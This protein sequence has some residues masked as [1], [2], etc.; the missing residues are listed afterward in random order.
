[1][2]K[3]ENKKE[4]EYRSRAERLAIKILLI[5]SAVAAVKLI[6][7]DYTMDEEYQIVMGYRLLQGDTLFGSMWEPHQTS[8]FL[9]AWLMGLYHL[10]TGSYTGVLV[11][12]RVVTT[13][14]QVFLAWQLYRVF[15]WQ[16][17][18]K[19]ALLAALFYFNTV[20]KLIQIPEFSNLQVWFFT[21]IYLALCYWRHELRTHNRRM[22]CRIWMVAAGV[23]MAAEVLAYPSCI[24]LFPFCLVAI[25]W[26]GNR[27]SRYAVADCLIFAGTCVLCGGLY[28]LY[29]LKNVPFS[30][31]LRNLHYIVSFDL[32]HELSGAA[33]GKGARIV[34]NIKDLLLYLGVSGIGCAA[35]SMV[36]E[37]CGRRV[38]AFESDRW[39]RAF[40]RDRRSRG[41]LW[42][43][44]M[45]I[46]ASFSQVF[47]WTIGGGSYEYYQLHLTVSY[48][49]GIAGMVFLLKRRA[50]DGRAPGTEEMVPESVAESAVW[51]TVPDVSLEVAGIIGS[52]V[53]LAAVVYIS[54]L[55]LIC[56]LP[57]ALLGAVL[58][59]VVL[60]RVLE[61]Q[62]REL[63]SAS[64]E[65]AAVPA[66]EALAMGEA[67]ATD[68]APAMDVRPLHLAFW[69]MAALVLC[70]CVGKGYTMR[71]GR[72]YVNVLQ[73]RNV[74]KSGPAVG[75]LAD[76]M[77]AY[78][79]NDNYAVWRENIEDGD[80]VLIVTN[81]VHAQ[82]TTPYLF[83]DVE[84]CHFSTVDPTSY[85]E[86][87]LTYWECY[88]EKAPNVIVVDCWYGN[89]MES[90]DSWIMK[91]IEE[92]FGYT[93]VVDGNYVRIYRK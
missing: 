24:I 51:G 71:A 52:L 81:M 68:E 30:E 70:S 67:Y 39:S 56:S 59:A 63:S 12:L 27:Y 10:V 58:G 8:A 64:G 11:F 50:V 92:D 62:E 74:M 43:A 73:T 83:R 84:V 47:V 87:L 49:M 40:G 86:K 3:R 89:L 91:Y 22:V 69:V 1:M 13:G 26:L 60:V 90:A 6:L 54:D 66:G 9:C 61:A 72:N 35:A 21:G 93:S 18:R 85:D 15:R 79:Y 82:S 88:P 20:P 19:T 17:T 45:G 65:C 4:A 75:V 80:R 42:C 76:Y 16:I 2:V 57:H 53:S 23:F 32:T 41:I 25:V 33:E 36:L 5:L 7:F 38:K 31:F 28:L 34:R 77:S 48:V 14:I 55:D 46:A 37:R 29:V 78:I 44:L